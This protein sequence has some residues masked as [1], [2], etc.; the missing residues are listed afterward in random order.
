MIKI[1][2]THIPKI[3]V[4]GKKTENEIDKGYKRFFRIRGEPIEETEMYQYGK[5]GR[6]AMRR[7]WGK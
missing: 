2:P 6:E 7:K 1:N 4:I 3:P 5:R